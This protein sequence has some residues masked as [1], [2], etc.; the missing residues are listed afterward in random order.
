MKIIYLQIHVNVWNALPE[1][2]LLRVDSKLEGKKK[3]DTI[4]LKFLLD[5]RAN[6]VRYTN[7][8]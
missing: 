5:I 7:S 2:N 1:I 4:V 8:R 6:I 3:V